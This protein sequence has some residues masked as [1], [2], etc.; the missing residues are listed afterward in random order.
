MENEEKEDL[1]LEETESEDDIYDKE[2]CNYY[3]EEK[4]L[5]FIQNEKQ[6]HKSNKKTFIFITACLFM[7]LSS[8]VLIITLPIYLQ[9]SA[10]TGIQTYSKLV[11]LSSINAMLFG[12]VHLLGILSKY[13]IHVSSGLQLCLPNVLKISVLLSIGSILIFW[14]TDGNYVSCHLQDPLKGCAIVFSLLFYY[15]F[16]KKSKY[17]IFLIIF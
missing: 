2:E 12:I 13:A 5:D 6:S 16:S 1:L 15:V 14:L 3:I 8:S 11:T 17:K 7:F 9:Y 4:I 10:R